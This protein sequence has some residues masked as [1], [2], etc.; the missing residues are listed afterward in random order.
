MG[1]WQAWLTN[2]LQVTTTDA[3]NQDLDNRNSWFI[4]TILKRKYFPKMVFR[5]FDKPLLQ[6][7]SL[8]SSGLSTP[9]SLWDIAL[10][11]LAEK[12]P[13]LSRT[14]AAS[15][16]RCR[17]LIGVTPNVKEHDGETNLTPWKSR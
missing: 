12:S 3:Q 7:S 10:Q 9:E 4:T 2:H 14:N 15:V 13:W 17:E 1:T 8:N 5:S 6:A 11:H 16:H